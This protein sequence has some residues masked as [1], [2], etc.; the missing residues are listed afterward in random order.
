MQSMTDI[1]PN[2][3]SSNQD[4]SKLDAN[5][6]NELLVEIEELKLKN[7][8]VQLTYSRLN[9][10]DR[11][12]ENQIKIKTCHQTTRQFK[13]TGLKNVIATRKNKGDD[14]K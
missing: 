9:R 10:R 13:M 8:R 1:I 11:I 7:K 3:T 2:E 5:N 6:C 14:D 4:E 12:D